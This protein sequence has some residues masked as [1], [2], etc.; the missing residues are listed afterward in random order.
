MYFS[1]SVS[2]VLLIIIFSKQIPVKSALEDEL[3]LKENQIQQLI[4]RE[5]QLVIEGRQNEEKCMGQ[6]AMQIQKSEDLK[7]RL[8]EANQVVTDRNKSVEEL[9]DKLEAQRRLISSRD[10]VIE[11]LKQMKD[12][13]GGNDEIVSVLQE[14]L[15][16]MSGK[17]E[18]LVD[19]EAVAKQQVKELQHKLEQANNLLAAKEKVCV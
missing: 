11:Q 16:A 15:T 18:Q 8:E 13:S 12:L 17:I 2:L 1:S 3:V 10:E 4:E 19:K 14:Q 7:K 9:M 6:L 5:K